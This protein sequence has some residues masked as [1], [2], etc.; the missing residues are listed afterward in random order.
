[1]LVVGEIKGETLWFTGIFPTVFTACNDAWIGDV[2]FG[3]R[4]NGVPSRSLRDPRFFGI[5]AASRSFG[6]DGAAEG[7]S[8]YHEML[9]FGSWKTVILG[10]VVGKLF[11]L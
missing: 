2:F 7:G 6:G 9:F 11:A 1:M 5:G 8:I 3:E 10:A 4:N